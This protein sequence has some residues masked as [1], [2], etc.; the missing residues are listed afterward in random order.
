[1]PRISQFFGITIAMFYNDHSPAHFHATYAE[2][3]AMFAV[4]TLETIT[5]QLPSRATALVLEWAALHRPEL[6]SN[7]E[8]ARQG[9]A[10]DA[11]KPLS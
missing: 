7:W 2:F 9:V 8:K 5:G 10:L 3:E 4:D 11:I 1:M 6:R